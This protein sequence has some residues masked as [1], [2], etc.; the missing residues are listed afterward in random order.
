MKLK[1]LLYQTPEMSEERLLSIIKE[2]LENFERVAKLTSRLHQIHKHSKSLPE[3]ILEEFDLIQ[4]KKSY[5]SKSQRD[6]ITGF[7]GACMIKMAKTKEDN[8]YVN[9]E[10]ITDGRGDSSDSKTALPEASDAGNAGD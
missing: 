8:K 10:E 9:Y 7:V 6:M 2:D 1:E 5:L 4:D 3:I